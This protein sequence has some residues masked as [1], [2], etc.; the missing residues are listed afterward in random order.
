MP[1]GPG[2]AIGGTSGPGLA[3]R[4]VGGMGGTYGFGFDTSGRGDS[5]LSLMQCSVSRRDIQIHERIA[6]ALGSQRRAVV[7]ARSSMLA[8]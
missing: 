5:G 4:S 3:G 6:D 7:F 2:G 1:G 8:E